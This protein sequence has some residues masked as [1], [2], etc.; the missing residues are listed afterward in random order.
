[1]KR[2]VVSLLL[3]T[4]PLLLAAVILQLP[5]LAAPVAQT[6]PTADDTREPSQPQQIHIR[7]QVPM[8]L[9]V[10]VAS[11]I[12]DTETTT[13]TN[14]L[15]AL[16]NSI[17]QPSTS[18]AV[19]NVQS[20][21]ITLTLDIQLT[22]T[23]TLTTTVPSTI[24]LTLGDQAASLPIS[25]TIGTTPAAAVTVTVLALPTAET[26]ITATETLTP[27]TSISLTAGTALT[28]TAPSSTPQ[29]GDIPVITGT[30]S[31]TANLRSGPDT[32]FDAVGTI[33]AGT[34]AA[35]VAQNA[36][37]TWYLLDSGNWIA[38][39]LIENIQGEPPLAT[40]ELVTALQAQNAVTT[41]TPVTP[42]VAITTTDAIT[43]ATT[44]TATATATTPTTTTGG[45]IT[46]VPTPAAPAAPSQ[47]PRVTVD[48]NLRS[49]PGTEFPIIGGTITGQELTIVARNEAA[50]WFRL[51]N[52]GWV[53][54]GLVANPPVTTTV[55]LFTEGEETEEPAS[56]AAAATPAPL[57]TPTPVPTATVVL[58]VRENLYIIRV[59]GIVDGYD[60]TLSKIDELITQASSDTSML[61]DRA[62][63]V[64]MTTAITLLRSTSD[65]V[66]ALVAP[67]LFSDAHAELVNAA[68]SF[69]TAADL[70]AEGVDQLN[71]DQLD[72]AF[73]EITIGTSLLTRAENAV[74]AARP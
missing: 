21:G 42:T 35:V 45:S 69:T 58:G 14:L 66:R 49:G 57:S 17:A 72:A 44:P 31:I 3:I 48:A 30:V 13:N 51:D 62:W 54:A 56:T 11:L 12:T 65:E 2:K 15:G 37:A 67:P 46:L 39:F 55:P 9:S 20:V 32:T 22:I 63:I 27:S 6:V 26:V 70:L 53:S 64:E 16:I 38:A 36:D 34:V 52:G 59:D 4:L 68:T 61:Q 28:E 19:S 73:A 23:D 10:V 29:L 33:T 18:E 8:T 5:A 25:L 47:L 43:T 1:M 50:S 40:E 71:T 74:T 24:T 41:A 7:Q 60:F